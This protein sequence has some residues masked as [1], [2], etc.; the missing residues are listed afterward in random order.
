[1]SETLDPNRGLGNT[2]KVRVKADLADRVRGGMR[3]RLDGHSLLSKVQGTFLQDGMTTEA[4]K[5]RRVETLLLDADA[6]NSR[7]QT[8]HNDTERYELISQKIQTNPNGR[9]IAVV[10]YFEL[11]DDQPISRDLDD[12]RREQE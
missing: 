3:E 12:L 4:T 2:G 7:W 6:D 5:R 9:S 8:I 1:M 11:G 10:E